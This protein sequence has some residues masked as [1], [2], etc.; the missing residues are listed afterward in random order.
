MKILIIIFFT[1]SSLYSQVL[2]G[3]DTDNPNINTFFKDTSYTDINIYFKE[4]IY[5]FDYVQVINNSESLFLKKS[6]PPDYMAEHVIDYLNCKLGQFTNR[7]S[8]FGGFD[9]SI[10]Y[11]WKTNTKAVLVK[12][13]SDLITIDIVRLDKTK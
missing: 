11:K 12:I 6:P 5:G 9:S 2:W 10:F 13:R 4:N 8:I 7:D 1:T 3:I